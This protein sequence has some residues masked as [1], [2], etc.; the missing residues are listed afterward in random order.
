MTKSLGKGLYGNEGQGSKGFTGGNGAKGETVFNWRPK[1]ILAACE[2]ID[3]LQCID[4]KDGKTFR[5]NCLAE[6]FGAKRWG[7]AAGFEFTATH[8]LYGNF[9]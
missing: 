7:V 4:R 8:L 6:R 2:Q 9:T 1:K 5:N 3:L